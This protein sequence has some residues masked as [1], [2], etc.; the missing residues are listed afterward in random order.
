MPESNLVAN[1][2]PARETN[3]THQS[4]GQLREDL[5]G[6]ASR[7]VKGGWARMRCRGVSTLA[8]VAIVA[9]C[10]SPNATQRYSSNSPAQSHP[11]ST[12]GY[13][14]VP[15]SPPPPPDKVQTAF[16]GTH[17]EW[18]PY[19]ATE[20][21]SS[22]PFPGPGFPLDLHCYVCNLSRVTM[23][24]ESKYLLVFSHVSPLS[25]GGLGLNSANDR[26]ARSFPVFS[27]GVP[28]FNLANEKAIEAVL[29]LFDRPYL[30]DAANGEGLDLR[31]DGTE[32]NCQVVL[33][34]ES[35]KGFL[36]KVDAIDA[37]A[38]TQPSK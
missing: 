27:K 18:D 10:T 14:Y 1:N 6:G 36:K 37:K 2:S 13:R 4:R 25:E 23:R 32:G 21:I 7:S 17:R 30:T 3:R 24:G 11:A 8:L 20:T 34:A 15:E 5:M 26:H 12:G 16:D 9:G 28:D 29:I 22:P 33:D 35:I 19:K 38:S 31:I